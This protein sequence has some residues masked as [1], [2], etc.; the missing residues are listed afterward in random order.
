MAP[1]LL[2]PDE[3]ELVSRSSL[4]SRDSFD[5]DAADFEAQSLTSPSY[6]KQRTSLLN[7]IFLS[8]PFL[9]HQR[10]FRN[11]RIQS[12]LSLKKSRRLCHPC[13]YRRLCFAL[14]CLF[15]ILGILILFTPIFRPSYTQRPSHY[16]ILR[17]S[18]LGSSNHGRGNPRNEKVFIAAS[19]YDRDG[20]LARGQWGKNVLDLIDILGPDNTYLS[21]YE[22][23]SG[24]DSLIALREMEKKVPCNH[25]MIYEPHLDLKHVQHIALPGSSE[26]VKR[27]AFLAEVRNRALRPLDE[28]D[29]VRFD[30]LL[31]LNDVFFNPVDAA[32]L[33]FSTNAN[34]DGKA[35]YRAACAVDF[36]NAFKFYDTF[37][38]RDLEGYSTGVPFY[39]WFSTAGK[40]ESRRD[41]L[42]QRDAVRVR[43]CWG[44]MVA[45]D[46]SFFQAVSSPSLSASHSGKSDVRTQAFHPVRFRAETDPYWDASE[47]CLIHADIQIPPHKSKEPTSTGI[48]MN[49]YIRVAYDTS[50]LSW[51]SFTRRFE[52]LYSLPHNILN[53]LVGMPWY[54]PR[55]EEQGGNKVEQKVWDPKGKSYNKVIRTAGTGGF[56][57]RRALQVM[58][59]NPKKGQ[60]NWEMLPVPSE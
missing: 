5:L 51:L 24:D 54:N 12:K 48:Y 33:L 47:C 37:A 18:I 44:G 56:C 53:H 35:Q 49:P 16:N 28:P 3:Y 42:E 52:R 25:S 34:D 4:D 29:Q 46:A 32:Q 17:D 57:G 22:N 6:P 30:K 26:R 13:R 55:R 39:P 1:R 20:K 9:R 41:I 14:H 45:F 59:T 2:H 7:R 36:I 58:I 50:T 15:A 19:I 8:V 10:L 60:K 11:R 23:D 31:Y 38:A 27:I 43:S 21:V 40:G